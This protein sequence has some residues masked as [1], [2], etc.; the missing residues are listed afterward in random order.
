MRRRR[1]VDW[2]YAFE[3]RQS[4]GRHARRAEGEAALGAAGRSPG[5]LL[6]G[7][8]AYFSHSG[9][10]WAG[11]GQLGTSNFPFTRG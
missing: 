9:S 11:R 10:P 6:I 3:Q 2:E 1:P 8:P 7:R 4:G 5:L